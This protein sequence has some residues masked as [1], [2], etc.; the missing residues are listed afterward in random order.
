[1]PCL[2]KVPPS[3]FG[4][5]LGG[6]TAP[7]FLGS[8]FQLPTLM[9]FPLR[10]FAPLRWSVAGLPAS[11][12]PCAFL[13]NLPG[14][15]PALRRLDPT[16]KPCSFLLPRGLTSGRNLLLPWALG[17]LRL[18]LRFSQ[19]ES[20]SLPTFPSRSSILKTSRPQGPGTPGVFL[21]SGLALSPRRGRRPV[22]PF[23]PTACPTS[24]KDEPA[25]DYFFLSKASVPSREPTAFSLRPSPSRLTGGGTPFPVPHAA[26]SRLWAT[27][28][29][30]RTLRFRFTR[31]EP[32]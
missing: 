31:S 10:S 8:L 9:G 3:G 21:Q 11:F 24:L 5:P 7:R 29:R 12:R 6:L 22:W 25:A 2:P 14:L 30:A 4:Y 27:G 28:D 32:H 26:I 1:L 23:P 17:P 16:Q 19:A 13:Q 18:S 20:F 15:G